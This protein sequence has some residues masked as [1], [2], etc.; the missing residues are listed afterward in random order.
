MTS[1]VH[2]NMIKLG[3][4]MKKL[5][6]SSSET[7]RPTVMK[8]EIINDPSAIRYNKA[9]YSFE[10]KPPPVPPPPVPP[11]RDTESESDDD[12]GISFGDY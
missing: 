1:T 12:Y 8:N 11:P 3:K 5:P 2:D 9:D 6:S 10:V 7:V 4:Q